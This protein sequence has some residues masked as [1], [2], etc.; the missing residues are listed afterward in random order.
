MTKKDKDLASA[1]IQLE[2]IKGILE[3]TMEI[4]DN[5]DKKFETTQ[6]V[7]EIVIFSNLYDEMCDEL[8]VEEIE[9]MGIS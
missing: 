3:Q 5:I 8:G 9:T 4:V 6:N 2:H 1:R 7:E